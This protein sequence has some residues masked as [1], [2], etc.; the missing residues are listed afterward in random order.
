MAIIFRVAKDHPPGTISRSWVVMYLNRSEDIVKR[1]WNRDPFDCGMDSR[2]E[3]LGQC[4]SQESKEIIVA[5][6]IKKSIRELQGEIEHNKHP[7]IHRC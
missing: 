7:S 4:L 5:S 3:E 1:N 6:L 2:P